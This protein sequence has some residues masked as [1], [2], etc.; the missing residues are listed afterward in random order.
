MEEDRKRA[1]QELRESEEKYRTLYNS[2]MD[3]I[4]LL[5]PEE[6]FL[7]GNP[8]AVKIFGCKDEKEFTSRTLQNLSPQ[9]QPDGT[10][11]YEKD[12]QMM[13]IVM[14][15]GSHFFEWTH[16]RVDDQEFPATVLLTRMEL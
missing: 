8:A 15:K 12:K 16:K 2:S 13:A 3:A 14:E 1:E 4:M 6:G 11:S 5:T 7:S 9:Y 10:L